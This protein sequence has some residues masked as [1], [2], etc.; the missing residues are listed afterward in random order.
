MR[1]SWRASTDTKLFVPPKTLK[2]PS[3]PPQIEVRVK[4]PYRNQCAWTGS[5]FSQPNPAGQ[6]IWTIS[7][8]LTTSPDRACVLVCIAPTTTLDPAAAVAPS[9]TYE[10]EVRN[11][12]TAPCS[13]DAWI[14]RDD[15]P[16]GYP[17]DVYY[18][19][20]LGEV[21]AGGDLD[22]E[23]ASFGRDQHQLVADQILAGVGLDQ[24]LL[25]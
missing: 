21:E 5:S 16:F 6:A 1:N 24:V 2:D 22:V 17:S 23:G 7:S 9:G 19:G 20:Q 25:R 13:V 12:G 11:V 4:D 15:T 8:G 10:V 3:A 14:Q 18:R